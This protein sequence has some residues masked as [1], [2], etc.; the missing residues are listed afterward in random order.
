[1]KARNWLVLAV[2]LLP[3]AQAQDA[4]KGAPEEAKAGVAASPEAPA[5][6]P[7]LKFK[8]DRACTCASAL[9]EADI[10]AAEKRAAAQPQPRRS[11]K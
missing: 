9:G 10:E 8:S 6:K 4:P 5:K 11:E 2:A 7:R 3:P 1:M